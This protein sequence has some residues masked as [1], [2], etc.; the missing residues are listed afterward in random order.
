MQVRLSAGARARRHGARLSVITRQGSELFESSCCRAGFSSHCF[1]FF[2]AAT[3]GGLAALKALAGP[4]HACKF[5]PTGGVTLAS[6]PEWL[7][8][9]PVLCVGGSW[10]VPK[11]IPDEAAIEQAARAAAALQGG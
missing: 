8:F 5:C 1:K 4:F 11:G 6:A 3:S 10:V 9:D 7:A 2:P